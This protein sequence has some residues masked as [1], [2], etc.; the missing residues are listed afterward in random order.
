VARAYAYAEAGVRHLVLNPV[1]APD[2]LLDQVA[3][4]A[5]VV[6]MGAA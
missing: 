4:L 1:V 3:R 2:R 5:D 6:V